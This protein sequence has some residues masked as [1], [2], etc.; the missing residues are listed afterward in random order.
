MTRYPLYRS[1]GGPQDRS[2][3]VEKISSLLGFKKWSWPILNLSFLLHLRYSA[4][5]KENL[6]TL[7]GSLVYI[8]AD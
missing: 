7:H 5:N 6:I 8:P 1:L 4:E 3:R 2:G